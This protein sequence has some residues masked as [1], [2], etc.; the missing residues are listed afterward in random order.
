MIVWGTSGKKDKISE[1]EFYCPNCQTRRPYIR[2]QVGKYFDVFWIKLFK[3]GE[4]GGPFVECQVCKEAYKPSV[5]EYEPP[6]PGEQFLNWVVHQL[7]NGMPLH[8]LHEKLIQDGLDEQTITDILAIATDGNVS[9]CSGCGF[10]YSAEVTRCPNCGGSLR[11][12]KTLPVTQQSVVI[13]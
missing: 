5:L 10:E 2:W 12:P 9:E 3:V 13:E 4:A 11:I 8:M 6:T 7:A 1:G